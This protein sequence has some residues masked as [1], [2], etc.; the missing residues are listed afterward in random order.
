MARMTATGLIAAIRSH[1]GSVDTTEVSDA[2]ILRELNEVMAEIVLDF[3]PSEARY[4]HTISATVATGAG[5]Y[6]LY[7]G[8]LRTYDGRNT[9]SGA[10]VKE[11]DEARLNMLKVS[12]STGDPIYYCRIGTTATDP[13]VHQV[14]VWPTPTRTCSI[15]IPS[16][17]M[18]TAGT[19]NGIRLNRVFDTYIQDLA[20]VRLLRGN[21]DY[22]SANS[23]AKLS[24]LAGRGAMLRK[25]T[26][27]RSTAS[28]KM[29]SR[30][31]GMFP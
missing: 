22:E 29:R 20:V 28:G 15:I 25:Q 23:Y 19:P 21:R 26:R 2:K 17:V 8:T 24:D 14:Y 3:Q 7:A 9:T 30:F 16:L 1:L 10:P 13:T 18:P 12:T 5:P 4:D 31:S 6:S 27:S 11:I